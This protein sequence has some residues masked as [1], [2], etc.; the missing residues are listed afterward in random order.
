MCHELQQASLLECLHLA[1]TCLCF[2]YSDAGV[3]LQRNCYIKHWTRRYGMWKLKN[4]R[5]IEQN[6][7]QNIYQLYWANNNNIPGVM[8]MCFSVI[9]WHI[10]MSPS[11]TTSIVSHAKFHF[12]RK[13]MEAIFAS[14]FLIYQWTMMMSKFLFRTFYFLNLVQVLKINLNPLTVDYKFD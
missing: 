7:S 11:N 3:D 9:W 5:V 12:L 10:I 13:R 14:I 1:P 6:K 2:V 8:R 4:I